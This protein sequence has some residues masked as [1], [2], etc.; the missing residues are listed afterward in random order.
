MLRKRPFTGLSGSH[1]ILFMVSVCW[2]GPERRDHNALTRF[3]YFFPQKNPGPLKKHNYNCAFPVP[4]GFF[5]VKS[6]ENEK[7]VFVTNKVVFVTCYEN[8]PMI[9]TGFSRKR[10]RN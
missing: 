9:I 8:D 2:T 5:P 3:F 7:V 10:P 4:L 1:A 6:M